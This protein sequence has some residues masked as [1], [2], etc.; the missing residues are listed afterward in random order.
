MTRSNLLP[1]VLVLLPLAG[2]VERTARIETRPA[3]AIVVVNDEEVG[4]SPVRFSFLWYGDYEIIVRKPG[5]KTLQT[6]YRIEPPWYQVPPLDFV[7]EVMIPSVIRDERRF[8]T[9]ELVPQDP[10]GTEDIVKRATDLRD[11]A[12]FTG[13]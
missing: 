11:R 6:H 9:Y 10:P 12:L 3:G 2:C 13:N 8:P 5:Y 7:S 1:L 4:V